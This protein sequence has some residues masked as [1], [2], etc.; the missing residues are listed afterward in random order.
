MARTLKT[1][2]HGKHRKLIE[3]FE[4]T[5]FGEKWRAPSGFITD[6]ASVPWFAWLLTYT[7]HDPRVAEA[8]AIH[9][10]AYVYQTRSQAEADRAF[11]ELLLRG[12][13]APWK[14][15][16]MFWAVRLFGWIAWWRKSAT[17][18]HRSNLQQ[19]KPP[20]P[21]PV[22]DPSEQVTPV[23]GVPLDG[24]PDDVQNRPKRIELVPALR[25]GD[26]DSDPDLDLNTLS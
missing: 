8:S 10:A 14:A 13:A 18:L 24:V 3:S 22:L 9:D 4:A 5:V 19:P 20:V 23:E 11:L 6:G 25:R 7:P 15:T 21:A 16:L 12:E 2:P 1:T 26:D 17:G